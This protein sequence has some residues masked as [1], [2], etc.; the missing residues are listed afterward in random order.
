MRFGEN[1]LFRDRVD[2]ATKLAVPLAELI[3]EKPFVL[4]I[5]RGGAP[6]GRIVAD[7]LAA[8]FNVYISRKIGAPGNP[9]F[10]IGAVTEDGTYLLDS[11]SIEWIGATPDVIEASLQAERQRCVEYVC[12]FRNGT[13]LPGFD[14]KTIIICDDGLATGITMLAS[15]AALKKHYPAKIIA[16]TPV[17]SSQAVNALR[18]EGALVVACSIPSDFRAVAMFYERFDQ[19]TDDDVIQTLKRPVLYNS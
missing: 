6:I 15:V 4:G 17:A 19:L 3:L 12:K 5:P 13:P 8:E 9:E 16:A 10:G 14:G 1:Y 7:A 18:D 2:A 11:A